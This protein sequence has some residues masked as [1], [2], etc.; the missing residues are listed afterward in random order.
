MRERSA[1]TSWIVA[2]ASLTGLVAFLYPFFVG[3]AQESGSGFLAHAADAPVV[4]LLCLI[5]ILAGMESRSLGAKQVALLGVLAAIGAVLRPLSGY[6]FSPVFLLPI[7]AGYVCGPSFGFLLGALTLLVS[8][9]LTSGV[10]P[11]LPYQMLSTGWV[12][13]LAGW[14]PDLRRRPWME[15]AVLAAYAFFLGL[16]FGAVMNLWFWPYLGVGPS[17]AMLWQPGLSLGEAAV[18]Y[19]RFYLATSLLWDLGRGVG[20]AVLILI[21][22]RPIL[23]LL[24]RFT[25]R[26]TFTRTAVALES[27]GTAAAPD[28]EKAGS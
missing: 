3:T 5:A 8:A 22:G 12:G 16:L 25:R 20:N 13:M 1:L 10:G 18:R 28:A 23:R 21:A 6:S 14:L 7:L 24:R 4:T 9:L 15:V 26:F 17:S 19:A 2:L 27:P 11:W